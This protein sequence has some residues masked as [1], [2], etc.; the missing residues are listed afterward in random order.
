MQ[1]TICIGVPLA[2]KCY[3][4]WEKP[5]QRTI[6]QKSLWSF[7]KKLQIELLCHPA[8]W[9]MDIHQK[10]S[11]AACQW[12]Y[13]NTHVSPTP[14]TTAKLWNHVR[15]SSSDEWIKKI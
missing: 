6:V 1:K 9:L 12:R 5:N 13:L 10:E 11:K 4:H 8:I 7:L 2:L 3:E 14:F 15:C